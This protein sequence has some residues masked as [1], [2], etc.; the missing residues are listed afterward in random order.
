[1][2]SEGSSS[3]RTAAVTTPPTSFLL[4]PHARSA[5]AYPRKFVCQMDSFASSMQSWPCLVL[6]RSQLRADEEGGGWQR[7]LV[8]SP[9]LYCKPWRER[10]QVHICRHA[11]CS[12]NVCMDYMIG[13]SQLIQ[14]GGVPCTLTGKRRSA[15]DSCSRGVFTFRRHRSTERPRG[16]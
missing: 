13:H 10:S 7:E 6:E 15:R 1:M 12:Q 11:H 16:V 2:C 9:T 8:W 3:S 14:A 4:A 5:L